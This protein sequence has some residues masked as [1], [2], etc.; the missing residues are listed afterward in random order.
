MKARQGARELPI[1]EEYDKVVWAG[2]S[3]AAGEIRQ[4]DLRPGEALTLTFQSNE[5]DPVTLTGQVYVVRYAAAASA[6]SPAKQ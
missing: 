2:L 4:R 6:G 3:W 1:H 5:K